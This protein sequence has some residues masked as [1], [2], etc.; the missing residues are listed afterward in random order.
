MRRGLASLIMG[1]SLLVATASWAGFVMSRTVLDPGRSERL[2]DV[3]LDDPEIRATI[4]DRLADSAETQIPPDI[5]VTR[6]VIETSADQALDDPRVEGLIRDGLVQAHQNALNGIDEP[7]MLDAAALGAAGRDAIVAQQPELDQFLP[8][9]PALEVELPSTGLSWLGTVKRYVDRYTLIGAIVAIAGVTTAF[10]LA[11]NRAAALRRIAFWAIGASAFWI[12]AAYA[13]PWILGRIAPSSVSIASAAIDVFFG[14]MIRPALTLAGAGVA[15][16]LLSFVW[17]AIERRRP[18]AQLDRGAAQARAGR[19]DWAPVAAAASVAAQPTPD[20]RRPVPPQPP[21]DARAATWIPASAPTPTPA[22]AYQV[23]SQPAPYEE[24]PGYDDRWAPQPRRPV[25]RVDH[26][27]APD[28]TRPFP[29]IWS[30]VEHR[31]AAPDAPAAPPTVSSV[32]AAHRFAPP[33]PPAFSGPPVDPATR[34]PAPPTEVAGGGAVGSTIPD[35]GPSATPDQPATRFAP[36]AG[37]AP[38]TQVAGGALHE[39]IQPGSRPS[40]PE[41]NVDRVGFAPPPSFDVDP[42][43]AA[44]VDDFGAEWV[45]GVGYVEGDSAR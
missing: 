3:L 27:A 19:G 2:A 40:P 25:G 12:A 14:A 9:A 37:H 32:D 4:V 41:P 44:D 38:P 17:P 39:P 18:A 42:E 7:V 29:E 1:L 15:L 34:T 6:E 23:P 24:R 33:E 35:R 10:V 31:S 45:E 21:V 22:A 43:A 5:P 36:V 13:L 26:A 20:P 11:R 16:L 28:P 30:N 8:A